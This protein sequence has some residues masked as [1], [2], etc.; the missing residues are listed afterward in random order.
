M[1]GL[2][3]ERAIESCDVARVCI[4][5]LGVLAGVRLPL[6]HIRERSAVSLSQQACSAADK[7]ALT[8]QCASFPTSLDFTGFRALGLIWLASNLLHSPEQIARLFSSVNMKILLSFPLLNAVIL[9]LLFQSC[10]TTSPSTKFP[11]Y[12]GSPVKQLSL[13]FFTSYRVARHFHGTQF[14]EGPLS[15]QIAYM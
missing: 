2:A 9:F 10:H 13:P 12:L 11:F 14:R 8:A 7:S 6:S 4:R 5:S 15:T 1:A 3:H